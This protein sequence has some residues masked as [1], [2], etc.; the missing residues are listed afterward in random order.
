MQNVLNVF[1]TY[2]KRICQRSGV[3]LY[4]VDTDEHT[5]ILVDEVEN[6]R[7]GGELG[8]AKDWK[9]TGVRYIRS[10]YDETP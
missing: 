7:L 2:E 4:K 3:K 6:G 8:K 5:I 1:I 10:A 9:A